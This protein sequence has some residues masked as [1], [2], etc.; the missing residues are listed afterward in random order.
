LLS[1]IARFKI[2]RESKRGDKVKNQR[3]ITESALMLSIFIVL[4]LI[5]IYVPLLGLLSIWALPIPFILITVRRG[6]KAGLFLFA[7]ALLLTIAFGLILA[8]PVAIM[9]A[10]SGIVIGIIM[11]RKKSVFAVLLGASLSYIFNILLIYVLSILIFD[12]NIVDSLEK[13]MNDSILTAETV[14]GALGQE[15]EKVLNAYKDAI[16]MIRYI[17]PSTITLSG[18]FLAIITI[19]V[20]NPIVKRFYNDIPKAAPFREWNFPKSFIWYYLVVIFL[21]LTKLEVGSSLYIVVINLQL[22]LE[23]ILLIQGFTFIYYYFYNK[24]KSKTYPI[25]ITIFTILFAPLLTFVKILGIIDLGF[26][27][28]SKI[29]KAKNA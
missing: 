6:W 4:L 7:G 22:M 16:D 23:F 2:V 13:M 24:G 9:F 20:A 17:I 12:I 28:K 8:L 25:V 1:I 15:N 19:L 21:S 29:S 26:E 3:I 18:I 10:S 11:S 5:T 27:L 14:M